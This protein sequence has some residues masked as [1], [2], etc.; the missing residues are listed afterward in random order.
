MKKKG[1]FCISPGRINV[2]GKIKL[3]CFD[4]T[5]TLTEEGLDMWGVI[6]VKGRRFGPEE[7]DIHLLDDKNP[8][9]WGLATCHSLTVINGKL[10]GDPL[11]IKMFESTDWMLEEAGQDN[12]KF[13]KMMPT[14][15][16]PSSGSN[17]DYTANPL[18]LELGIIRQLTF[19]SSLARM[20]VVTRQ[21]GGDHFT[22]FTKGAPEKLETLCDADSVPEDFHGKLRE[23]TLSGYRVIALAARDL[24][25][26]INWV[27]V[28][29]LKREQIE[30]GLTF[31][32]FLVM[33][34]T[35]K[36]QTAG[37]IDELKAAELRCLMITGD[38]LLTAVSVARDCGLVPRGD[39]VVVAE[40]VPKGHGHELK[41]SDS[42]G[43]SEALG[44]TGL[45]VDWRGCHLAVTGR[46]WSI[47]QQEF[48]HLVPRFLVMGTVF[49][50]MSPDQKARL[51]EDLA[52]V[53]YVVA[54]CGD[55]ANDC[56]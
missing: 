38:N 52:G 19:S 44:P 20:S 42:E 6:P 2:C 30:E 37:V 24:G 15:V 22:V 29:K 5:G 33:Q 21:L 7:R 34:N 1:I 40:A 31:L 28:H 16:R 56:G 35:L 11:D 47:I 13:D 45:V 27:S 9:L 23:L 3:I 32:G 53:G 8:L 17:T 41:F 50:R 51:V 39:R 48:A 26:S 54:M 12:E 14:V 10:T 36:P 46:S 25:P 18:P 4:K 49:A 55:G 43:L